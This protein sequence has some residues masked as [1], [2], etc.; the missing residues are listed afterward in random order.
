MAKRRFLTG[1]ALV[2][3]LYVVFLYLALQ[4]IVSSKVLYI[5]LEGITSY[6]V[7]A[8]VAWLGIMTMVTVVV[9]SVT[10]C[11]AA[12]TGDLSK[13]GLAVCL[14]MIVICGSVS[15]ASFTAANLSI[16]DAIAPW[17]VR[18]VEPVGQDTAAKRL[19]AAGFN[20]SESRTRSGECEF[21]IL[22]NHKQRVKRAA[23]LLQDAGYQV[24]GPPDAGGD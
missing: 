2:A 15:V 6:E 18:V 21:V 4:A 8:G 19:R 13:R 11:L 5:Y 12:G 3:S 10:C 1:G 16:L 9:L 14:T 17:T 7:A 20:C 24:K 23:A 22:P